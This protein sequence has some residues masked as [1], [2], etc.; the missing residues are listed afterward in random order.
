MKNKPLIYFILFVVLLNTNGY[1]QQ[2]NTEIIELNPLSIELNDLSLFEK[3]SKDWGLAENISIDRKTNKI[4]LSKKGKGILIHTNDSK[5]HENL[6]TKLQH[7][8]IAVEFDVML[9]KGT[10]SSIYLQGKYKVLLTDSWTKNSSPITNIGSID[11]GNNAADKKYLATENV[12]KAPGLWQHVK[13]VFQAPVIN[14]SG[15]KIKNA[16]FEE[17]TINNRTVIQ[18]VEVLEPSAGA[19]S[20][21]ETALGPIVLQGTEKA[22]AFKNIS[23]KLNTFLSLQPENIVMEI[24]KSPKTIENNNSLLKIK[25]ISKKKVETI[26]PLTDLKQNAANLVQYSGTLDIPETGEYLFTMFVSGGGF[27]AIGDQEIFNFALGFS[28]H[29]NTVPAPKL[30]KVTLKKGKTPFTI[31]YNKKSPRD[32]E[33][34]LFAEGEHMQ[35]YSMVSHKMT[36]KEQEIYDMRFTVLLV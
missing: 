22:I 5:K 18:N 23:Y 1:A 28:G 8:N 15:E 20:K 34:Q 31:A 33:F 7:G 29:E 19:I 4:V 36:E 21:K 11:S 25:P 10:E 12:A 35:R 16:R 26:S 14:A 13:I 17:I 2:K 32:R 9:S 3:G 30:V 6:V 27:M 24:K